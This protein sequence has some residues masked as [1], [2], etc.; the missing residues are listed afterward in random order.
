MRTA[1]GF[2]TIDEKVQADEYAHSWLPLT[3]QI[4]RTLCCRLTQARARL[5]GAH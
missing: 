4:T 3:E 1:V 2:L 5:G